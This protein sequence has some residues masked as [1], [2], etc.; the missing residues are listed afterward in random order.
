MSLD[1]NFISNVF[2]FSDAVD[3]TPPSDYLK[4]V[5]DFLLCDAASHLLPEDVLKQLQQVSSSI[6]VPND[7]IQVQWHCEYGCAILIVTQSSCTPYPIKRLYVVGLDAWE[8]CMNVY[9]KYAEYHTQSNESHCVYAGWVLTEDYDEVMEMYYSTLSKAQLSHGAG[10]SA[11]NKSLGHQRTPGFIL[12]IL[13]A[14]LKWSSE[15]ALPTGGFTDVGLHTGGKLRAT[16]WPLVIAIYRAVITYTHV[17]PANYLLSREIELCYQ[18]HVLESVLKSAVTIAATR[19]K[20]DLLSAMLDVIVN[21]GTK[22]MDILREDY[23]DILVFNL[24]VFVSRC[25]SVRST[26]INWVSVTS[27]DIANTFNLPMCNDSSWMNFENI[28]YS[29]IVPPEKERSPPDFNSIRKKYSINLGLSSLVSMN[30]ELSQLIEWMKA[31]SKRVCRADGHTH[32]H[33]ILQTAE[34]ILFDRL[35][36]GNYFSSPVELELLVYVYRETL[37]MYR[38]LPQHKHRMKMILRSHEL[39]FAWCAYC[40][41]DASI[42]KS[43]SSLMCGYGVSLCEDD[44]HH[45]VV[46]D[47]LALAALVAV[48]EYLRV[49]SRN[50]ASIFSHLPSDATLSFA[51]QYAQSDDMIM[52]VYH[53]ELQHAE[54]RINAHWE[55]VLEKRSKARRLKKK[56]SDIESDISNSEAELDESQRRDSSGRTT[57]ASRT[58]LRLREEIKE[59]KE[60]LNAKKRLLKS[61]EKS[62]DPVIQS[63]PASKNQ[64]LRWLFFL[65][66]NVD[67][68]SLGRMSFLAQQLTICDIKNDEI[69]KMLKVSEFKTVL[70]DY[71]INHSNNKPDSATDVDLYSCRKVPWRIGSEHID[72]LRDRMDG[73][74]YPDDFDLHIGWNGG[75]Q[76]MDR[77]PDFMDVFATIPRGLKVHAFTEP[78]PSC[79]NSLSLYLYQYGFDIPACRGNW[80]IANQHLKPSWM[81]KPQYLC[82]TELRAYPNLQLRKL[83]GALHDRLLVLHHDVVHVMIRQLLYHTGPINKS[84]ASFPEW[85]T[86]QYRCDYINLLEHRLCELIEEYIEKPRDRR[87]LYI[88]L[89]I[90]VYFSQWQQSFCKICFKAAQSLV[91]WAKAIEGDAVVSH[92]VV[93]L[94]EKRL[95]SLYYCY[96]V[97]SVGPYCKLTVDEARFLCHC[98]LM[99]NR[100]Y[101][102]IEDVYNDELRQIRVLSDF[103]MTAQINNILHV[104][105]VNSDDSSIFINDCLCGT[106]LNLPINLSW[107]RASVHGEKSQ[108]F[109]ASDGVNLYAINL[110]TGMFLFNGYPPDYLPREVT[111]HE[112]YIRSFGDINF[113]TFRLADGSFQTVNAINGYIYKFKLC[114]E[115]VLRII[116]HD[117]N[118]SID[119]MLLNGV[120]TSEWGVN[121]PVRLRKLYSHWYCQHK[122]AI[123][124]RGIA[125]NDRRIYFVGL[126]VSTTSKTFRIP[127]HLESQYWLHTVSAIESDEKQFDRS[128]VNNSVVAQV[129]SKFEHVQF[130]HF[131]VSN[132]FVEVS[133]PRYALEFCCKNG[134][135]DSLDHAGFSLAPCQQLNDTLFTFTNYL[136]LQGEGVSKVLVPNGSVRYVFNTI[137]CIGDC[138]DST[139]GTKLLAHAFDIHPRFDHLIST[140]ICSR[141]HLAMLYAATS[142]LLFDGRVSMSGE[143][144]AMELVRQCWI[145]KPLSV[146]ERKKLL[147]LANFNLRIPGL[148]IICYELLNSSDSLRFLYG[149]THD[150]KTLSP[151]LPVEYVS[152]YVLNSK[153]NFRNQVLSPE[154]QRTGVHD[155]CHRSRSIKRPCREVGR[156]CGLT[157]IPP[158]DRECANFIQL[159]LENLL[160]SSEPDHC[161]SLKID[162]PQCRNSVLGSDMV[163]EL[164]DSCNGYSALP[165]FTLRI[166]IDEATIVFNELYDIVAENLCQMETF[167]EDSISTLPKYEGGEAWWFG[168]RTRLSK[169]GSIIPIFSIRDV[170]RIANDRELLYELNYAFTPESCSAYLDGIVVYLELCVMQDKLCRLLADCRDGNIEHIIQ[171]IL[172][173]RNWESHEYPEWLAFEAEAQLQI[174][175]QQY[176]VYRAIADNPS[177]LVQMNMGEGKTRVIIP[178]L[179]LASDKGKSVLRIHFLAKLL[180]E[181]FDYLHRYITAATAPRKLF[182]LPF[183]RDISLTPHRVMLM[184]QTL[185]YCQSS[186]GALIIAPE[187]RLSLQLK[188]LEMHHY[189]SDEEKA[190]ITAILDIDKFV[191]R[192]ILDE[193]DEMLHHKYQLIYSIGEQEPLDCGRQ[194]Y[195]AIE[196]TLEIID[197]NPN[198][199]LLLRQEKVC[200]TRPNISLACCFTPIRLLSGEN[201]DRIWPNVMRNIVSTLIANPP[202]SLLWL[203]YHSRQCDIIDFIVESSITYDT[204]QTLSEKFQLQWTSHKN[205]ILA[206]RGLLAGGV[207]KHCLTRRHRVNFGVCRPHPLGKRMAVPFRAN[208]TPTLRAEFAQPD[209]ALV[210][211]I[212]SYYYDGL[213]RA[214]LRQALNVLLSTGPNAQSIE[215]SLWFRKSLCDIEEEDIHR[216]DKVEKI[217]VSNE[218]QLDILYKYYKYNTKAIDY[219]LNN[220]LLSK[221]LKQFPGRIVKH[222]WD[223]CENS[224]GSTNGFSGTN[225]NARLM[226]LQVYQQPVAHPMLSTTNG[227]MVH[228]LLNNDQYV[229]VNTSAADLPQVWMQILNLV[230]ELKV[231]ALI[232]A[233]ALLSGVN[234]LDAVDYLLK[235]RHPKF[236]SI[237][238]FD[239]VQ[240]MWRVRDVLGRDWPHHSSPIREKDAFVI[241]DEGRCRGADMKLKHNAVALLTLGPQMQ[242][243]VL[244]QAAGRMRQLDKGQ[245]LIFCGGDDVTR[246]IINCNEDIVT[247]DAISSQHIILWTLLNTFE[248]TVH[249]LFEWSRQGAHFVLSHDDWDKAKLKDDTSLDTL[250]FSTICIVPIAQAFLAK[251]GCRR[252]VIG[253]MP[254]MLQR[255]YRKVIEYGG[256]Y[257]VNTMGL[258][259]EA[260]RELEQEDEREKEQV[261]QIAQAKPRNEVA[262]DFTM[263]RKATSVKDL[264]ST[265]NILR[266]EEAM[267]QYLLLDLCAIDWKNAPVYVTLNFMQ[268]L[269]DTGSSR[270]KLHDYLRPIDTVVSFSDGTI[271]LL[272]DME[273]NAFLALLWKQLSRPQT[274]NLN[275]RCVFSNFF[276]YRLGETI[277]SL[278]SP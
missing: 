226:P 154:A 113:E 213:E 147:S 91:L 205:D 28:S 152:R 50:K 101:V 9:P 86:D 122:D 117:C 275:F 102:D 144:H 174:R 119:M 11:A 169:C 121:L 253:G 201:L 60:S 198:I 80:G 125:Y 27:N 261:R 185:M 111:N 109:E 196:A 216:I 189:G 200:E 240:N 207:L 120:E 183:H 22:L 99:A 71:Y 175:P 156:I 134:V 180:G 83:C 31:E 191:F 94:A 241:F 153:W 12:G 143:E 56:I 164:Q 105:N 184:K 242:K 104:V 89:E 274:H 57:F 265:A 210:F 15:R 237:V 228:L 167:L 255:I 7:E 259:E 182:L 190:I 75:R 24:D 47:K 88:L 29:I 193:C 266:L 92:R 208:D 230:M 44:L 257:H 2:N 51:L 155:D 67:F 233:G 194:R 74:Y 106:M 78:L 258:T 64:A 85:K 69:Q 150:S 129:L 112:V 146:E 256:N 250:Y 244:M 132:Y 171:E 212:L 223:L 107:N 173:H 133:F 79:C 126:N 84:T 211:T 157:L 59:C 203:K 158:I 131:Y 251:C 93:S 41:I 39:L 87:A 254:D 65:Y 128:V 219:W 151:V 30:I 252:E 248:A 273:A 166:G 161:K 14:C 61:V 81:T 267:S 224:L 124:M 16:S 239:I 209:V 168:E 77:L 236:T 202:H 62:P 206:L 179:I 141:L 229:S 204:N 5:H 195:I 36:S 181:G 23:K 38:K 235:A 95:Q 3:Q 278:S 178:M 170:F 82:F 192:D 160:Q 130:I 177:A 149:L 238:Y 137:T 165:R 231:D 110:V 96:A 277:G 43:H 45:C 142:S 272:S 197:Q 270:P 214:E 268:T 222:S 215:Y 269:A 103:V 218:A 97:I 26:I 58:T 114:E 98:V 20:V 6:N 162:L 245:K 145:N 49:Q 159:R 63:L 186:G 138:C 116:E 276:E 260:E 40:M 199:Q 4:S 55:S 13:N 37:H 225:D 135:F 52:R 227:K 234:N 1:C 68:A 232:D 32:A 243:D 33:I 221:E 139:A 148:A 176:M 123:V 35:T 21:G 34:S 271:L 42:R 249:G 172:I 217:D 188:V 163:N 72:G 100:K 48:C 8:L 140:N 262:W 46:A 136:V 76:S 187:H 25:N 53:D 73:I 18:L 264:P 118:N 263:L 90:A 127:Q 54:S 19:E 70:R 115:D 220:C 108:C 247:C 66:M 17:F 10:R 246:H